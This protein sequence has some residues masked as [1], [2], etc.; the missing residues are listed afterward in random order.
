MKLDL[1]KTSWL[2]LN[3]THHLKLSQS[4]KIFKFI[5]VRSHRHIRRR[6]VGKTLVVILFVI[7]FNENLRKISNFKCEYFNLCLILKI[8]AIIVFY[9]KLLSLACLFILYGLKIK[10]Y[11]TYDC[12]EEKDF[13]WRR[14]D[15]PL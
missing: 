11:F 3:F 15:L 9:F 10:P 1:I 8:E 2:M 13:L 7:R 5:T 14:C 6:I 12:R 4:Y